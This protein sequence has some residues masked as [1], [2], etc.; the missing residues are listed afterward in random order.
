MAG[1]AVA[2]GGAL[3]LAGC[4]KPGVVGA[5]RPPALAVLA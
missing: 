2:M 4:E 3:A 1:G 5:D